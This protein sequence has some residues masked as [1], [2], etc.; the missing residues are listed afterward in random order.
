M[1]KFVFVLY[2]FIF[3]ASTAS[4]TIYKWTDKRGV[5]NFTDDPGDIP[6]EY[7]SIVEEVTLSQT[8][9]FPVSD[10]TANRTRS[11]GIGQV[12]IREGDFAV[13]LAQAL[14]MGRVNDETEAESILTTMGIAPRNGW[15]ADYPMTP[16]I[17]GELQG[18]IEQAADS[19]KLAI[20]KE[21]A[22]RAL[23]DLSAREGLPLETEDQNEVSEAEPSQDYGD[24]PNPTVVNNYYY[25]EGPPVV[26]YYLPPPVYVYLYAW[27]PYP[28]RCSGHRFRGFFVL[29]DFSKNVFVH[30]RQRR[31]TNH[32]TDPRT[33][34]VHSIDPVKRAGGEFRHETAAE[35]REKGIASPSDNRRA[36]SILKKSMNR[37]SVRRSTPSEGNSLPEKEFT[38][39]RQPSRSVPSISPPG[40]EP[41]THHQLETGPRR[42][43]APYPKEDR[44][45]VHQERNRNDIEERPRRQSISNPTPSAP[46]PRASREFPERGL[47]G[48][49]G[50]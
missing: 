8:R 18:A 45:P 44:R 22:I 30:H 20:R 49:G 24:Y 21:E 38:S 25:E 13:E 17:V 47:A 33:R 10:E 37:T 6:A 50:R 1:K 12:L 27:V 3:I 41:P 31:I 32:V 39:A 9:T 7:R 29:R 15:I 26:T 2:L 4:A 46:S 48:L 43:M 28:F 16:D 14:K 19:G 11:P 35:S 34:K 5:L 36:A 42:A 23:K 40:M